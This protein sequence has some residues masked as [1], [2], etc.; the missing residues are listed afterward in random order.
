M[1]VKKLINTNNQQSF[2]KLIKNRLYV[3]NLDG[4]YVK[5]KQRKPKFINNIS[6]LKKYK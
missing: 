6:E 2:T 3:L 5:I 4:K 1:F